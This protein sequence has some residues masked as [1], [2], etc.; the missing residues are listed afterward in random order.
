MLRWKPR[1]PNACPP[2]RVRAV[3]ALKAPPGIS[4]RLRTNAP[5]LDPDQRSVVWEDRVSLSAA[6]ARLARSPR[7]KSVVRA[8]MPGA[9]QCRGTPLRAPDMARFRDRMCLLA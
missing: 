6:Q 9:A 5:A 4:R 2:E 1:P 7:A 3:A 8:A